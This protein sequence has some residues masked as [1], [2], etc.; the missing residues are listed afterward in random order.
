MRGGGVKLQNP[1]RVRELYVYNNVFS[2][3][4][5]SVNRL[6]RLKTLKVFSNEVNL[7]PSEVG[8]FEELEHLHVKVSCSELGALPPLEKLEAL[9]VLELFKIPPRPSAFNLSSEI[10]SL[11]SLTRL[12]VCHFSIS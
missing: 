9:K 6:K 10:Y 7:F 2:M 12:S 4:P 1:E 11:K 3:I 5:G 8:G